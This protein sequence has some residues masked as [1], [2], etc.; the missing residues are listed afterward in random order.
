MK[1]NKWSVIE[2][3]DRNGALEI[4]VHIPGRDA[5]V[6]ASSV[7]REALIRMGAGVYHD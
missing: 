7:E 1:L 5:P 2:T 4:N 6:L 3:A